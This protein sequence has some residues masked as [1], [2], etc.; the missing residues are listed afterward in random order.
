MERQDRPRLKKEDRLLALVLSLF[1]AVSA[2]MPST[3]I[4]PAEALKALSGGGYPYYDTSDTPDMPDAL[5][6]WESPYYYDTDSYDPYETEDVPS[7]TDT[8]PYYGDTDTD[9]SYYDTETP[10][11]PDVPTDFDSDVDSDAIDYSN[12]NIMVTADGTTYAMLPQASSDDVPDYYADIILKKSEDEHE[13]SLINY[14]L[15]DI[16]IDWYGINKY[17]LIVRM[18]YNPVY[19]YVYFTDEQRI[20]DAETYKDT[21]HPYINYTYQQKPSGRY[22]TE[23]AD[24]ALMERDDGTYYYYIDIDHDQ[25]DT[26]Y[27]VVLH[28]YETNY[29]KSMYNATG[30]Y[31]MATRYIFDPFSDDFYSYELSRDYSGYYTKRNPYVEVE[32]GAPEYMTLT[33]DHTETGDIPRFYV[34]VDMEIPYNYYDVMFYNGIGDNWWM[35]YTNRSYHAIRRLNYTPTDGNVW[36]ETMWE[37][38]STQIPDFIVQVSYTDPKTGNYIVE[39]ADLAKSIEDV[40]GSEHLMLSCDWDFDEADVGYYSSAIRS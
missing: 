16:R 2:I 20:F 5:D 31:T 1:L 19:N 14:D 39:T 27:D 32:Y 37:D 22:L 11:T 18:W 38:E 17:D 26:G 24:M 3:S 35:D 6:T 23:T 13:I 34:D 8:P 25:F 36:W 33:Y 4:G 12:L 10:C 40:D 9:T 7:T 29:G 21:F 28:E 30:Y 15:G